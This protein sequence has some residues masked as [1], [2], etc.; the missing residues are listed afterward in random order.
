VSKDRRRAQADRRGFAENVYSTAH[1]SRT[2]ERTTQ[3]KEKSPTAA[4]LGK[5]LISPRFSHL[6]PSTTLLDGNLAAKLLLGRRSVRR[7][8]RGGRGRGEFRDN[9]GEGVGERE[10][11]DSGGDV[12]ESGRGGDA[13]GVKSVFYATCAMRDCLRGRGGLTLRTVKKDERGESQR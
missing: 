2:K 9:V 6:N 11:F 10:L 3:R 13:G 4:T 1:K 7:G 12:E 5:P 8:G